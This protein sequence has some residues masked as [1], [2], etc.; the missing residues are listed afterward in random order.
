MSLHDLVFVV[1]AD[2]EA[3]PVAVISFAKVRKER[4]SSLVTG[5]TITMEVS[6]GT[7]K[8]WGVNL[9]INKKP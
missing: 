3:T 2:A 9:H 8:K 6:T 4:N 1:V 7:V 5:C